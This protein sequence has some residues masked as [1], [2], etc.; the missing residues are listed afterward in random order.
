MAR[1]EERVDLSPSENALS[2]KCRFSK[3]K[4]MYFLSLLEICLPLVSM[5][6]KCEEKADL[7]KPKNHFS[8]QKN[9]SKAANLQAAWL[10]P[11]LAS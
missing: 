1:L 10:D 4:P 7:L 6:Q 9:N 3:G 2:L 5:V 8:R 11:G